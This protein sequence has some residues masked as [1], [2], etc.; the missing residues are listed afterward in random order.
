MTENAFKQPTI[1]TSTTVSGWHDLFLS[2]AYVIAMKSKDPSTRTGCVI[3][4]PQ[5]RVLSVGFNGFPRG[6]SDYPDR[7]ADRPL[8]HKLIAHCDLNAIFAAAHHGISLKGC[9]MYLTHPPCSQCFKGIIQVGITE[10]IWP[11]RNS[12]DCDP[13]KVRWRTS[14]TGVDFMASEAGVKLTRYEGTIGGSNQ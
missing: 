13:E 3:T 1:H 8:K 6:I 14:Q 5:H 4:D 12:F 2:M 11:I 9:T 7:Y 10:V